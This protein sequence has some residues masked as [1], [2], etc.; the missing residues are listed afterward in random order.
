M[1]AN[2]K[3]VVRRGGRLFVNGGRITSTGCHWGGI[4]VHGKSDVAQPTVEQAQDKN[5]S[6]TSS[7]SG[8]VWIKDSE[9]SRAQTAIST[10][11]SGLLS[12]FA[13]FGGLV[14]VDN[15]TFFDN[16]RAIEFMK[17][18]YPNNS[19]FD[20]GFITANEANTAVCDQG[21]SIWGCRDIRIENVTFTGLREFGIFGIDYNAK[22]HACTFNGIA[23]TTGTAVRLE[24]THPNS[25]V[26][27]RN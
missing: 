24:T 3:I 19:Y 9:I 26:G 22:I 11:G 27:R 15:S 4:L 21:I 6:L 20:L 25:V 5:H 13:Y 12:T 23:A 1:E 8:V 14:M 2:K 18:E 10:K 17:Y 7:N 16:G